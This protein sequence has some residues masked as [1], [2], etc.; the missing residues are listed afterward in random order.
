MK[1][2]VMV[3]F[4]TRPEAIKMCP[5]VKELK[6]RNELETIVSVTGQHREMLDQVLR[7]F[8]VVPDY[9]LSIMKQKQTLF[10]ITI[11][12]LEKTKAVLEEVKPDVVLVHGVNR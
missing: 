3:V 1:R 2:K 5:V 7:A 12:I 10:D 4:G 6:T 8:D 9:D 11:N